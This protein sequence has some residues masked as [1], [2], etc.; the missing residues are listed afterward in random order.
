MKKEVSYMASDSKNHIKDAQ[1]IHKKTA[2]MLSFSQVF[3]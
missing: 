3:F 2:Q 1:T